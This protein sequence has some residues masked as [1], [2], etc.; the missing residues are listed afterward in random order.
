MS[1]SIQR[2]VEDQK[3][4]L[5][6]VI[7]N[8]VEPTERQ[9]NEAQRHVTNCMN[10]VADAKRNRELFQRHGDGF[11]QAFHACHFRNYH[12]HLD[13][14]SIEILLNKAR[15]G[16]HW[17][18]G[19]VSTVLS[20]VDRTISERENW[21]LK[22][23]SELQQAQSAYNQ[24]ISEKSAIE[25]QLQQLEKQ[26][27][28]EASRNI[29]RTRPQQPAFV[30]PPTPPAYI[31]PSSPAPYHAENNKAELELQRAE[32]EAERER[33]ARAE[34]ERQRV[35]EA[36]EAERERDHKLQMELIKQKTAEA[37]L[38]AARLAAEA[39]AK[40]QEQSKASFDALLNG[41]VGDGKSKDT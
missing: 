10:Y 37:Q 33:E 5:R 27:Q 16:D 36:A 9:L 28:Q 7:R 22:Y 30:P 26:A 18:D 20:S 25:Q 2:Q 11:V 29:E 40:A 38:E 1:N 24:A 12:T 31:P 35:H 4:R 41:V 17:Q 19:S 39:N 13:Q 34:A 15:T 14:P 21:V 6:E 8:R 3:D 32:L 23:Q